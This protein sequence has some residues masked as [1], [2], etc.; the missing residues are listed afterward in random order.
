MKE[1][2]KKEVRKYFHQLQKQLIS[3]PDKRRFLSDLKKQ[4]NQYLDDDPT[5]TMNDV[6]NYFG[7]PSEL[8]QDLMLTLGTDS[9]QKNFYVLRTL[10][11]CII[12]VTF[13]IIGVVAIGFIDYWTNK[14]ATIEYKTTII[15]TEEDSF[16][17]N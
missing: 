1:Q 13:I 15:M 12:C 6:Y 8:N 4:V 17:E 14:P 9:Y 10:K 3:H 7:T 5:R 11:I 16:N 2:R